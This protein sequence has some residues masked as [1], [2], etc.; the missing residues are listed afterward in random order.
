MEL[1]TEKIKTQAACDLIVSFTKE[2]LNQAYEKAFIKAKASL[3]MPGFRPGKV[4]DHLAR[5]A[6]DGKLW[7]DSAN[8]LLQDSLPE[9]IQKL[10]PPPFR[11][12]R[13]SIEELDG[14][15]GMKA[16]SVYETFPEVKLGGFGKISQEFY[17]IEPSQEAIDKELET[18]RKYLS[19]PK[20]KE[21]GSIAGKG[22]MVEFQ[23]RS[24]QK[25][26]SP[27]KKWTPTQ[28]VIGE[29][30]N[31]PGF[32][33]NLEG[34]KAGDEK[35]FEFSFP[36]NPTT[37]ENQIAGQTF[38]YD[39]KVGGVYE[40]QIPEIND[41]L[42]IDWDGSANLAELKEKIKKTIKTKLGRDLES[43]SINSLYKQYVPSCEALLPES[44]INEEIDSVYHNLIHDLKL[45][46]ISMEEYAKKAGKPIEEL[47]KSFE[48]VALT[49][50]K[51]YVVRHEIAK[52]EKIKLSDEDYEKALEKYAEEMNV[53]LDVLKKDIAEKKA[54]SAMRDTFLLQK[55]DEFIIS[56]I[57]KIGPKSVDEKEARKILNGEENSK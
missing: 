24:Y 36:A 18:I 11:L 37:E 41:D 28:L 50:V 20:L 25:N 9:M 26:E 52:T 7:E 51:T 57:K 48:S 2:E 19:K 47:R 22:D 31:A 40:I 43:Y 5:K 35:T 8:Q 33:E 15:K 29:D 55:V 34:L 49:R 17:T 4:P 6:L 56:K 10:N 53:T 38:Q 21:E 23:F 54:D 16:K 42:A 46:H 39:V 32:T 44:L 27:G 12:G 13:F 30:S 3:K 45:P 1:K 14:N